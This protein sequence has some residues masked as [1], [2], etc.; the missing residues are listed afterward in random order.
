M[1]QI[2]K[3]FWLLGFHICDNCEKKA[4]NVA[5]CLMTFCGDTAKNGMDKHGNKNKDWMC[6]VDNSGEILD[7]C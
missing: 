1:H 2:Y 6:S 3:F 5:T 7:Y 4:M